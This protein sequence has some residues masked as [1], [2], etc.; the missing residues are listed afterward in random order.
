MTDTTL[1]LEINS[2]PKEMRA[3]VADFVAFLKTKSKSKPKLKAREFGF[4]KGKIKLSP[5][6]DEPLEDFNQYM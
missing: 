4:A 6:F 5:D 3:E 1:K 2:L